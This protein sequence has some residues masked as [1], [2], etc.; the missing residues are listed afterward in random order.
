[1]TALVGGPHDVQYPTSRG[2]AQP[3]GQALED[4][5]L[6]HLSRPASTGSAPQAT[7]L[8]V[9]ACGCGPAVT[10]ESSQRVADILHAIERCQ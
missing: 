2:L 9:G 5:L 1:M 3:P 4:A 7:H 6:A 10:R 8:G